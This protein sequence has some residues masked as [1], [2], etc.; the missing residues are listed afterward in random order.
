MFAL[1]IF[2]SG[3]KYLIQETR[4]FERR[5]L[6]NPSVNHQPIVHRPSL[7]HRYASND[8]DVKHLIDFISFLK[9]FW[10][11]SIHSFT[12]FRFFTKY[13]CGRN[14]W[15]TTDR[16]YR[17]TLFNWYFVFPILNNVQWT[18]SLNWLMTITETNCIL[19]LFS[20]LFCVLPFGFLFYFIFFIEI[21]SFQF[22]ILSI[23][24]KWTGFQFEFLISL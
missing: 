2:C 15:L 12:L 22:G 16:I 7:Y 21:L 8:D 20:W 1:L 6:N 14:F 11:L 9:P 13:M 19:L 18:K 5:S 3:K 17:Q 4:G 10:K 24:R 23:E